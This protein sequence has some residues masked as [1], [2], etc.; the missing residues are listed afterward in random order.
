MTRTRDT[1][2]S[3]RVGAGEWT[4]AGPA[5]SGIPFNLNGLTSGTTYS[6]KITPVRNGIAKK[7][8]AV[9]VQV[10]TL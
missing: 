10:K 6:V 7:Q 4:E 8:Q 3:Y 5:I 1:Q 2:V 9:I